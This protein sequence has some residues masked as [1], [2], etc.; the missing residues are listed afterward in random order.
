MLSNLLENFQALQK[1]QSLV[2][3]S[4][5]AKS[6]SKTISSLTIFFIICTRVKYWRKRLNKS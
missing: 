3:L 5:V 6:Q 2:T 1:T 4:T